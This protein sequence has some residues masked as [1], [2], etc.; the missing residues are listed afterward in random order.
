MAKILDGTALAR[1]VRDEV[2]AGVAEMQQKHRITPGLAVVLVGGDP[3]S[4]IY[5][6]NKG[7]ACAEAGMFSEAFQYPAAAT[8]AEL[9]ELV[10]RVKRRRPLPRH[11]G[12]ASPAAAD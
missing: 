4:A 6:R 9:L 7:R 3:A 11:S 10:A 8:Q 12:P 5:V 2:A 1:E